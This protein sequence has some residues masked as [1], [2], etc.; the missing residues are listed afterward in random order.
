MN[1]VPYN[2]DID[3]E[4]MDIHGKLSHLDAIDLSKLSLAKRYALIFLSGPWISD[5]YGRFTTSAGAFPLL[6][7]LTNRETQ[8]AVSSLTKDHYLKTWNI[9]GTTC[10]EVAGAYGFKP[11][12][13][14]AMDQ[15]KKI[16]LRKRKD[17]P[18]RP[19]RRKAAD[20]G[21]PFMDEHD[22]QGMA[23]DGIVT[24]KIRTK[25]GNLVPVRNGLWYR[26]TV[27]VPKGQS[28]D[29]I[30]V[31]QPDDE[32]GLKLH[33]LPSFNP[34]DGLSVL[35]TV[36]RYYLLLD[37]DGYGRVR[38]DVSQLYRQ[39]GAVITKRINRTQIEAELAS[40]ER[41]GYLMVFR[42]RSGVFAFIR[43]SAQHMMKV[44]NYDRSIPNL[45]DDRE[46]TYDSD[47]YKAFFKACEKHKASRTTILVNTFCEHGDATEVREYVEL[48][49]AR[50]RREHE[51]LMK[52]E[53]LSLMTP[54]QFCGFEDWKGAPHLFDRRNQLW[55]AHLHKL[56]AEQIE[57]LY[58]DYKDDF[59]G[60][61][62]ARADTHN[63]LTHLL[64][65]TPQ[66]YVEQ[67]K[68]AESEGV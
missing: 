6:P 19:V 28:R 14:K 39:L 32:K 38:V 7:A 29:K 1:E 42:K 23:D 2:A 10:W 41:S 12:L 68:S 15:R 56:P 13:K 18:K 55:H 52:K 22:N 26:S 66:A 46:F 16:A 5:D 31:R 40:M 36:L 8:S 45:M 43:D 33:M 63:L 37:A 60:I 17:K 3:I 51:E 64:G 49:A 21:K 20:A 35:G 25:R 44:K 11:R 48:A 50:F 47:V 30:L 34:N 67:L 54:A 62:T 53:P 9:G 58:F 27:P 24:N 4:N 57:R 61:D 65:M 59:D